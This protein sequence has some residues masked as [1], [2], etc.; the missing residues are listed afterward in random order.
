MEPTEN[1]VVGNL[2]SFAMTLPPTDVTSQSPVKRKTLS[3]LTT[4][5]MNQDI[6]EMFTVHKKKTPNIIVVDNNYSRNKS[7]TP[8]YTKFC[9]NFLETALFY[10]F[11]MVK[12][13]LCFADS[14]FLTP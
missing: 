14:K 5:S 12:K 6:W 1:R 7:L 3:T 8:L 13:L 10:D 9:Q 4:V 2:F 11:F